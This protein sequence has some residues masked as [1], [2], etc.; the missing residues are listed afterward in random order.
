MGNRRKPNRAIS[1]ALELGSRF[2]TVFE[3]AIDS[4]KLTD[5]VKICRWTDDAN[6]AS[7]ELIEFLKSDDALSK[8][9]DTIARNYLTYRGGKLNKS[10]DRKLGLAKEYIFSEIPVLISGIVI[11]GVHYRLLHYSGSH[12]HLDKFVNDDNSLHNLIQDIYA[13]PEF[14]PVLNEIVNR[15]IVQRPKEPG[16]IGIEF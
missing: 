16:F 12:V 15:S 14:A 8:R 7:A 1:E 2:V 9:V 6:R 3:E 4:Q 13:D 5:R 11:D 10:F